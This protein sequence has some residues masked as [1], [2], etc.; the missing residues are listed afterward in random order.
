MLEKISVIDQIE[1][2][3]NGVIQIRT[4]NKIM[5]DGIEI[6]KAYHR[7]ILAPGSSLEGENEKVTTIANAVW[8]TE[9]VTAYQ[10]FIASQAVS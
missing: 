2:V 1:V 7:H 5:E 6:S 8:T 9:V 3:E 10:E 4:V